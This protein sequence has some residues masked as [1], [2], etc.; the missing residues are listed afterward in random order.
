MDSPTAEIVEHL[1][2]VVELGGFVEGATD[3]ELSALRVV[4]RP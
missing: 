4:A 2:Q 3:Q 1:E